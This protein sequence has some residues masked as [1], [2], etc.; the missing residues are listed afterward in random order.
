MSLRE[1]IAMFL[2]GLA[3]SGCSISSGQELFDVVDSSVPRVVRTLPADGW[4]EVPPGMDL[5]IWFSE[6][7]DPVSVGPQSMYV[8]SG[9]EWEACNYL[10]SEGQ[11][12]L[13]LVVLQPLKPLLAGVRHEIVIGTQVED[14]FGNNLGEEVRV[15]FVTMR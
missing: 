2:A 15:M 11:A 13:G 7:V 10:V 1:T 14:L 6:P 3:L 8:V 4:I 12:G 5:K 9:I